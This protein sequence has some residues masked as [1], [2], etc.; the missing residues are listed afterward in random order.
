MIALAGATR[1]ASGG[2]LGT[3]LVVYVGRIGSPLAVGLLATVFSI[4]LMV[5]SPLW[6]AVGDALGRL[7]TLLLLVSVLASMTIAGFLLVRNVWSIVGLRG[8]Y[9][10]FAVGF[11]PLMLSLVGVLSGPERRGHAAGFYNSS[12][13]AGDMAGQLL[14]GVLIGTLL[15][16]RLYVLI[17]GISLLG[18]VVIVFISEPSPA[19]DSNRSD[20]VPD[21]AAT[22]LQR[23]L[24]NVHERRLLR[25][26]GLGWLYLGLTLRH[27]SVKGVA[28]IVPIYLLTH[29]GV[30]PPVM[31]LLL[32]VGSATQIGF[33][34]LAGRIADIGDR[35][36]LIVGGIVVSGFYGV[37][38]GGATVF[39]AGA[40]RVVVAGAAFVALAVGFSAMDV[41]TIAFIGDV[42]P[43]RREAA[44]VGLRSTAAGL[45][46]VFGPTIVGVLAVGA[47]YSVAFVVVSLFAFV[48]AVLLLR[49]L[50][51]PTRKTE[52]DLDYRMIETTTGLGRPP[53]ILRP[54]D[55]QEEPATP[56]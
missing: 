24:P 31:G 12:T 13:A 14:V 21:V 45:G 36:L 9:A 54:P 51:F 52:P 22:A 15:P 38:M 56:D 34:P 41:G 18:T 42:V 26:T 23:L 16:S 44:F 28:S 1:A 25:E 10:A 40:M 49:F 48:S 2:M 27:L 7:R 5:F 8:V 3:A 20:E 37:L 50:S 55:E 43:P 35:K 19:P 47:G 53:G 11:A 39:D 32:T 30:S 4:G 33:M 6:G 17:A 29:V 46:G